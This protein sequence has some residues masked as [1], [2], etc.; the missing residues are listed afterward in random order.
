MTK[1]PNKN[2][3][4]ESCDSNKE[5]NNQY[6]ELKSCSDEKLLNLANYRPEYFEAEELKERFKEIS[7]RYKQRTSVSIFSN[8]VDRS[9]EALFEL[10]IICPWVI[11]NP[12][13]FD[14]VR[15]KFRRT[16]DR[17]RTHKEY[18]KYFW[19]GME[20]A[21]KSSKCKKLLSEDIHIYHQVSI[22]IENGMKKSEA[23]RKVAIEKG[24]DNEEYIR[25]IYS[26][27]KR[28]DERIDS[29]YN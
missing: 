1:K 27:L 25:Q 28:F 15:E 29:N 23:I 13:P 3:L 19:K 5:S 12:P 9:I 8:H 17:Q 10:L 2:T 18:Y 22:Y 21:K 20:K 6:E 26:S 4:N 16:M 11:E 14:W 7:E 24:R